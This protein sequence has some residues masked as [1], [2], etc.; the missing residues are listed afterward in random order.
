MAEADVKKVL[1][2][3]HQLKESCDGHTVGSCL[4]STHT[5]WIALLNANRL[6]DKASGASCH[7]GLI[8]GLNQ[9]NHSLH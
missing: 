6:K 4:S 2:L 7:A 9:A 5:V 3:K 8:S 1:Q